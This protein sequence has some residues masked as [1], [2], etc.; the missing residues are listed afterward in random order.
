MRRVAPNGSTAL[1]D[2]STD[3]VS[4]GCRMGGAGFL[5]PRDP[6]WMLLYRNVDQRCVMSG[7][8]HPY[9]RNHPCGLF[10]AIGPQSQVFYSCHSTPRH[11]S[12]LAVS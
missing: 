2:C 11:A 5:A 1:R 8:N 4:K 12:G 7:S 3:C 10:M 9:T 6:L